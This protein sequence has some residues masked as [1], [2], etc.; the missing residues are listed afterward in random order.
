MSASSATADR[1]A[2]VAVCLAPPPPAVAPYRWIE[3]GHVALLTRP[4][5]HDPRVHLR[6]LDAAWTAHQQR[7]TLMT[8]ISHSDTESLRRF[9]AP[10]ALLDQLADSAG[11]GELTVRA[12]LTGSGRPLPAPPAPAAAADRAPSGAAWLRQRRELQQRVLQ[13]EAMT[14]RLANATEHAVALWRAR[15]MT[16]GPVRITVAPLPTRRTTTGPGPTLRVAVSAPFAVLDELRAHL[17]A[18]V[19]MNSAE[20]V[21]LGP[22]CPSAAG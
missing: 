20:I 5:E 15:T 7:P 11:S 19:R 17:R 9:A 16:A 12:R 10:V 22:Y 18:T 4:M 6:D 3:A 21:V 14:T 13:R 1:V 2:V 8:R